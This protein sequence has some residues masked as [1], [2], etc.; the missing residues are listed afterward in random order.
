MK[1]LRRLLGLFGNQVGQKVAFEIESGFFQ[2]TPVLAEYPKSG[3]SLL[4]FVIDHLI[5][6]A[7]EFCDEVPHIYAAQRYGIDIDQCTTHIACASA[8]IMSRYAPLSPVK[9]HS[10][11]DPRFRSVICLFR[12]P[13]AVMRSYFRHFKMH[14]SNEYDNLSELIFCREN[15]LSAWIR[16]YESYL[17]STLNSL[18]FFCDYAK[19]TDSPASQVDILLQSVYGLSLNEKGMQQVGR[20]FNLGYGTQLEDLVL[21]ADPR[22]IYGGRFIRSRLP[23]KGDFDSLPA[24]FLD[25]C[26]SIQNRL[27]GLGKVGIA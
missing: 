16:F 8:M 24:H 6:R 10:L 9:T 12:D 13:M 17:N 18:V 22:R 5:R 11:F 21:G 1:Y 15:G 23:I 20:L 3:G 27:R 7:E 25:Q 4:F 2:L 14:G 26:T 19:L